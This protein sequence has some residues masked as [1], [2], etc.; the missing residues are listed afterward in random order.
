MIRHANLRQTDSFDGSSGRVP[1]DKLDE[2]L[3][4]YR[5]GQKVILLIARRD[6]LKRLN[7]TLGLEPANRWT[8]SVKPNATPAQQS[9]LV[10]WSHG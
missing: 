8:L 1:A 6:E 7:V 9:H 3:H 10:A 4:S 2:R 5:P